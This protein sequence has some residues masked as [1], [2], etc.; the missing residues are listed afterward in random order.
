M[1]R[2]ILYCLELGESLLQLHQDPGFVMTFSP[3]L[4]W[5]D[6]MVH[7]LVLNLS[8]KS[9]RSLNFA[10]TCTLI[11]SELK[12]WV[13]QPKQLDWCFCC[14]ESFH[15]GEVPLQ[16]LFSVHD[17]PLFLTVM[18]RRKFFK[19]TKIS[20]SFCN[21]RNWERTRTLEILMFYF[22]LVKLV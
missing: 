16:L 3:L 19:E 7:L 1:L 8:Q 4:P 5:D 21:F 12:L 17:S 14:S 13:G 18:K 15:V 9:C 22:S 10:Y 11:C 2:Q 20:V 6:I